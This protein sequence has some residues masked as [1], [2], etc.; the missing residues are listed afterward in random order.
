MRQA[1]IILLSL[2]LLPSFGMADTARAE[3]LAAERAED[4][5]FDPE[6]SNVLQQALEQ[7]ARDQGADSVSASLYISDRCY[8][9]GATGTTTQDPGLR[10]EP[11]TLYAF[12]SVAKTFVA[13]IVLQL[14]EENALGLDDTLGTWVGEHRTI[15]PT[16]T[17][18]QLLNHSSGLQDYMA[19]RRFWSAVRA[20]P[21]RI[22]SPEDVLTYVRPP[23][24]PPGDGTLY[25]NTNYTL[26][27]LIIEAVTGKPVERELETR[28]TGP[29]N[30]RTTSLRKGKVDPQRWS[31]SI[32]PSNAL[33]SAVWTAGAL[34]STSKDVAK[35]A[36]A[37]FAGDVLKA[38]TL[39]RML[40]FE[41]K[42][43]SDASIPMGLGVWNLSSGGIVAW[44]H[45]GLIKPFLAQ[46]AY[47]PKFKL[48][49]AYAS[50]GGHGQGIPGKH[51]VRAYIANRPGSISLCFKGPD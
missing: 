12:G 39:K 51:L 31:N 33:F 4:P 5:V 16:I 25:S 10:V 26:L 7:A 29:L 48:G 23:T 13:A 47:L 49:I 2:T 27:G 44:G 1:L 3:D 35:G 17:I 22:W 20:D 41:D 34:A 50:S 11:D 9:E 24:A 42:T 43:L 18:R 14:V 15:D 37:I 30:L 45:G 38:T 40:E 8:W 36:K 46:M 32:A 6:L 21:D 19:S 28:I